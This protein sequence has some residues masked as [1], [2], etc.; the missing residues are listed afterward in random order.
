MSSRT[1]ARAFARLTQ[2]MLPVVAAGALA[3]SL[4][5]APSAPVASATP[6]RLVADARGSATC[7]ACTL[8]ACTTSAR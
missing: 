2:L 1:T 7:T 3:L 6:L 4:L 5:A 8:D